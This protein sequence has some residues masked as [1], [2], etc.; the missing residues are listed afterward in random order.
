MN[1]EKMTVQEFMTDLDAV[2]WQAECLKD[3]EMTEEEWEFQ[4]EC[5]FSD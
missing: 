3:Q 2:D 5:P 1:Q 4:N